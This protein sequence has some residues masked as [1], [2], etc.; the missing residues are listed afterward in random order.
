MA[1]FK[2]RFKGGFEVSIFY[3][4]R[5]LKSLVTLCVG[6][7]SAKGGLHL[8][9]SQ[10]SSLKA[11]DY[12]VHE[13]RGNGRFKGIKTLTLGPD[14]HDC[15]EIEYMGGDKLM[16][17]VENIELISRYGG[18]DQKVSLDKLGGAG[19]Q[20]RKAS[21]KKKLL[22]IAGKLVDVA[23]AR[24]LQKGI[25]IIPQSEVLAA[26]ENRF[27]FEE[28]QDQAK[29]IQDVLE[30]LA[31]GRPMDRLIC[32]DVGFGK[33]EVALRAAF[34]TVDQGYQVALLAPTTLLA[35]QHLENFKFR[36]EGFNFNLQ[37]LS[38]L[39]P[40]KTQKL[41][42]EG[43]ENGQVDIVIGTHALLAGKNKVQKTWFCHR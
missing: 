27:P 29:A 17:P 31:S 25:P 4:F 14:R 41:T 10:A 36:F 39:V 12:L 11:R 37:G 15:A 40:P 38:R 9:I 3:F 32:G 1:L 20:S 2:G 19:W 22:E 42:K 26:F 18:E 8:L 13:D 6:Y 28:T 24:Q 33:T 7:P 21:V 5:T 35:R 23:A 30:D 16:L 43:I 34:A